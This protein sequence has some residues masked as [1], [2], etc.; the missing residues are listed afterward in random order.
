MALRILEENGAFQL[1]GSLTATTARSFIIHF[2][3][4]INTAKDVTV[5]IE[6]VK[7]ID[8]CGVEALKTLI[9]IALQSNNMFSVIGYGCK[10]IYDDY[11]SSFAA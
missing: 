10:D 6:K 11:K 1:H 9:A 5:N 8:A 2:E 4:I 3:H 7:C